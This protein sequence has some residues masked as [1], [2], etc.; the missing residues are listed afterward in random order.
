MIKDMFKIYKGK[1]VEV[2][3]IKNAPEPFNEGFS[4]NYK[5]FAFYYAFIAGNGM[6]R[7]IIEVLE[8]KYGPII[9]KIR[10]GTQYRDDIYYVKSG[11][12]LYGF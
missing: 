4:M 12:D 10:L 9:T 11:Y 6:D 1:T 7:R 8:N 3:K 5:D 2:L